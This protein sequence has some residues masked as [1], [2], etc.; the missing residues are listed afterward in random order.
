MFYKICEIH[1]SELE[2]YDR[3]W[4]YL[5]PPQQ[6]PYRRPS[7]LSPQGQ[8]CVKRQGYQAHHQGEGEDLLPGP[9]HCVKRHLRSLLIVW[10]LVWMNLDCNNL[11]TWFGVAFL[12]YSNNNFAFDL[13]FEFA[14]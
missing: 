14:F 10:V 1:V 8:S 13:E 6:S 4:T 7:S 5:W 12:D 3:S 2:Q 9:L 11:R